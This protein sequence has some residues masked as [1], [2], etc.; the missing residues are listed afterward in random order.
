MSF[1]HPTICQ[2]WLETLRDHPQ[3]QV[4]STAQVER[5]SYRTWGLR[6][7]R[8]SYTPSTD[9]Q[10]QDLILKIQSEAK[11]ATA[12]VTESNEDDPDFQKLWSLFHL[13]VHSDATSLSGLD[14]D[15][16]REVHRKNNAGLNLNDEYTFCTQGVFLLA[17]EE[18]FADGNAW[19]KCVQADYVAADYVPK[20]PRYPT[21]RYFG[22]MKMT[23]RSV[24]DLW[25]QLGIFRGL[26]V[27]APQ[28][29][30]GM[31]LV[32]WDWD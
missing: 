12:S 22:W 25:Y 9:Q 17:D 21:Q 10:W 30:G 27:I 15:Q 13:D 18:V 26:E 6:I 20:N 28:T 11:T 4:V 8:T 32:V 2:R 3:D 16:L 5:L 29:I 19:I 1:Q 23:T 24:A 7:Y 14:M 31:H